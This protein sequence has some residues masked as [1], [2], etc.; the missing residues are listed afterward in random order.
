MQNNTVKKKMSD[1]QVIQ[2]VLDFWDPYRASIFRSSNLNQIDEYDSYSFPI[3]ELLRKNASQD[4]LFLFLRKTELGKGLLSFEENEVR[5]KF[6]AWAFVQTW[7]KH[8]VIDSNMRIVHFDS[9]EIPDSEFRLI[10]RLELLQQYLQQWDPVKKSKYWLYG[11]DT[12]SYYDEAS[13]L[14]DKSI[15]NEIIDE[16]CIALEFA[17]INE[18]DAISFALQNQIL[19]AQV[20]QEA[21]HSHLME[22]SKRH[23]DRAK[24]LMSIF[25]EP[26]RQIQRRNQPRKRSQ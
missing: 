2:T 4:E 10:P 21:F 9:V 14:L 22:T 17:C 3:L 25:R 12:I 13:L 20:L 1:L 7:Q 19:K 24:L 26:N 11:A 18:S 15:E 23:Q 8:Q 16:I 6:F 5:N